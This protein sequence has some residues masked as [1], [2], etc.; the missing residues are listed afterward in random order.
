MEY[1][2]LCYRCFCKHLKVRS[3][4]PF[5]VSIFTHYTSINRIIHVLDD[6]IKCQC[7]ECESIIDTTKM[8]KQSDCVS[9]ENTYISINEYIPMANICVECWKKLSGKNPRLLNGVIID[10]DKFYAN[11]IFNKCEIS[12][13]RSKESSDIKNTKLIPVKNKKVICY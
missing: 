10:G 12:G 2:H 6:L 8:F 3:I 7:L 9:L 13:C 4:L 5:E 11:I 1:L